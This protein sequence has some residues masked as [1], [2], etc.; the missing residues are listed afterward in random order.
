[1]TLSR[2]LAVAG[3][4]DFVALDLYLAAWAAVGWI[5]EQPPPGRPSV[6]VM[7][8][9][10]RRDRIAGF[11]RREMRIFDA[12]PVTSLRQGT[13]CFAST[14][15]IAVGAVRELI[16]NTR[17]LQGGAEGLS[18][19]DAPTLLLTRAF[20]KSVRSHRVFGYCPVMMGALPADPDDPR[21][22]VNLNRSLRSM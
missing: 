10:V 2:I 21:A 3:P 5:I 17:P 14:G 13:A 22:P 11:A 12:T 19:Q 4:L 15:R 16:G 8:A 18:A 7:M 1:M 9:L 6:R 20:V